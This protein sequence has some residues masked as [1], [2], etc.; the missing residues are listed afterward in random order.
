MFQGRLARLAWSWSLPTPGRSI[1]GRK[2]AEIAVR[3]AK[4]RVQAAAVDDGVAMNDA[5]EEASPATTNSLGSDDEIV[6]ASPCA[7]TPHPATAE[8]AVAGGDANAAP[9]LTHRQVVTE[10]LGMSRRSAERGVQL[11]DA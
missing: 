8:S 1:G 4:G 10:S 7:V 6:D 3:D 11:A 5:D 9:E 2:R